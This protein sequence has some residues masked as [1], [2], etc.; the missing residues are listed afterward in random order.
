VLHVC[1]LTNKELAN[2]LGV[3]ECTVY[4][5]KKEEAAPRPDQLRN[6]AS[7]LAK[8]GFDVAACELQDPEFDLRKLMPKKPS[9]CLRLV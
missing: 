1:T 8:R 7:L 5:W 9:S 4:R 6:L 3:A 2:E